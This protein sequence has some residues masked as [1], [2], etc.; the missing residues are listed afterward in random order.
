MKS[1]RILVLGAAVALSPV[2]ATA[3]SWGGG[4]KVL[5]RANCLGF[6]NES[7]TYDRPQFRN[8]QGSAASTHLPMGNINP[9]HTLGAPNNGMFSWRFRAGDQSDPEKMKV[10]G[11]HTWVLNG[12]VYRASTAAVDCNLTEW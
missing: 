11:F 2:M 3:Q 5:S 12:G 10:T 4:V 1:P 6:I 9:K 8:V 7:I